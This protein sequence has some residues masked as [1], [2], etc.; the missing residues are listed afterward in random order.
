MGSY[1]PSYLTAVQYHHY[2]LAGL[3][4]RLT[5]HLPQTPNDMSASLISGLSERVTN[6]ISKKRVLKRGVQF[7]LPYL[8][9]KRRPEQKPKLVR[10]STWAHIA[11]QPRQRDPQ[12]ES[13]FS[14]AV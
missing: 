9:H 11:T 13:R 5:Y 7:A 1:C 10:V 6:P 8:V 3:V 14:F 12:T 2:S 4:T